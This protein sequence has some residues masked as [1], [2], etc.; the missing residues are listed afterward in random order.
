MDTVRLFRS[1]RNYSAGE[2]VNMTIWQAARATS[3]APTY[4]KRLKIGPSNAQEEFLNGGVGSNNPTKLM[5]DE[6]YKTFEKTR[7]VACVISIGAGVMDV[8]DLKSPTFGQKII[9]RELI[10]VMKEM[11]TDCEDVEKEVSRW[12]SAKPGVYFR[13]SVEK[14]LEDIKLEDAKELANMK[15]KTIRYLEQDKTARSI[16]EAVS[17]LSSP[18][19]KISLSDLSN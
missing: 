13:F 3:A 5:M 1:Y 19:A 9:P 14:G 15:T 4:F 17:I 7:S 16:A 18:T 6:A 12:F 10:N 11:V 2:Y 8:S